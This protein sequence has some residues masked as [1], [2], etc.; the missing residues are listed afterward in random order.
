MAGRAADRR[1]VR[2]AGELVSG[3]CAGWGLRLL[4]PAARAQPVGR[5]GCSGS[6]PPGAVRLIPP[7]TPPKPGPL[8]RVG[9]LGYREADRVSVGREALQNRISGTPRIHRPGIPPFRAHMVPPHRAETVPE[10]AES[11]GIRVWSSTGPC[12]GP[13]PISRKQSSR[14]E[15]VS[16]VVAP[17]AGLWTSNVGRPGM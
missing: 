11:P 13:H 1:R 17:A 8:F 7:L 3:S 12:F 15:G 9:S 16:A 5:P 14:F 6:S 4:P 2:P 10:T